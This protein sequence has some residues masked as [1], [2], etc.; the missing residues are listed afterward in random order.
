M[1]QH[2]AST[3]PVSGE[4]L[5]RIIAELYPVMRSITGPGVRAS[6]Q[7]LQDLAPVVI[8]E[9]P[10]GSAVLDWTVPDEW[11]FKEAWIEDLNG[12]RWVD[13]ADSNLHVVNFSIPVNAELSREDL[14]PHLHTL[15]EQPSRIPY[16]TTYYAEQWGFCLSQQTLDEMGPGPF[17]VCI[18][19]QR[20]PGVLNYGE[21]Y[22][23]G[24]RQQEILVSTHICHPQLANDNLSGMVLAAALARYLAEG[25][26]ELSWRFVFVPGTIGAISWLARNQ[27]AMP[28][29][30]GGLVITGL[31]DDSDFHWKETRD[32][33]QWID[34]LVSQTLSESVPHKHHRLPFSPYGYDER[35]YCSPGFKLPVGRL[36]RA[37]HGT[38][39][40]YHS[41]GDNLDFVTPAGLD[42]SLDLLKKIAHAANNDIIYQNLSPHGEP[43]LGRRGLY[44]A[45]GANT[46]PGK[47]Q[48]CLLW[49]LNQSDG[50]TPLSVIAEKSGITMQELD[51]AARL[52]QHHQLLSPVRHASSDS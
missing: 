49:L 36:S 26:P 8:H 28:E 12:R 17:K 15:P 9:V 27:S 4:Y 44:S 22:I 48:M 21:L 29:I 19:A 7:K 52:L 51:D 47:M 11:H 39:P 5:H 6:L 18:D 32:G 34:R 37:V 33:A 10:S 13:S 16:R 40:E 45:L 14:L 42:E 23:P 20:K 31:G 43:Q 30:V 24:N 50:Q 3:Q 25:T 38:F 35:Q 1:N 46:D 41:S 2:P